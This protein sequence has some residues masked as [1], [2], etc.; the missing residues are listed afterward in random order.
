MWAAVLYFRAFGL[1]LNHHE[2]VWDIAQFDLFVREAGGFVTTPDGSLIAYNETARV[3]EASDTII[4]TN[5]RLEVHN[6]VLTAYRMHVAVRR[7]S[8]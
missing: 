8:D 6:K 2:F 3:G 7:E 5:N 4:A 1:L